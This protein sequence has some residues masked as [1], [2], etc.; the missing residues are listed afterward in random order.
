MTDQV[1]LKVLLEKANELVALFDEKKAV[2]AT[3]DLK[4]IDDLRVEFLG[5]KGLDYRS[6]GTY[7]RA[8]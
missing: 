4:K 6:Y 2:E 3:P 1:N 7:E 5:R 8:F